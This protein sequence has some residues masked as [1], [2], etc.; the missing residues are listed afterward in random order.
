MEFSPF[1]V[2][3]T[4]QI[5]LGFLN[6][7]IVHHVIWITDGEKEAVWMFLTIIY[8]I[9]LQFSLT[10]SLINPLTSTDNV[11]LSLK[12]RRVQ[13]FCC[14]LSVF[15]CRF[16]YLLSPLVCRTGEAVFLSARPL[17]LHLYYVYSHFC[18]CFA[19]N[20]LPKCC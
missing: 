2:M 11:H 10:I 20:S 8:F 16:I 15:D 12:V 9:N 14:Q 1:P 19:V 3:R 13:P 18:L 5:I 17:Q 4:R 6:C 7:I